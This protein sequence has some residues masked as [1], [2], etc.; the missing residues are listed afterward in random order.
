MRWRSDK[1]KH[2]L[3]FSLAKE[4]LSQKINLNVNHP[5]YQLFVAFEKAVFLFRSVYLKKAYF[6]HGVLTW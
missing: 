4:K 3:A 6:Y 5:K 1:T 2:N